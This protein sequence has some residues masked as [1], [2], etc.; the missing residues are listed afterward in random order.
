MNILVVTAHPLQD[1]L[2]STFADHTI[3]T[4]QGLNHTIVHENLYDS[5]FNPVLSA[6]EREQ[7]YHTAYDTSDLVE[8]I[9]NLKNAEVLILV[10]PTWWF[11]VPA[12]MKGWFD[13]V[14]APTVAYD[15]ASD[16]GPIRPRLVNLKK[17]LVITTLGAPWWV[18]VLVV[19]RPVQRV[20]RYALLGAC[21]KKCRYKQVS[22]YK[23]ERVNKERV[24]RFIN[25]I[26]QT[27]K[28]WI[29]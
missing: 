12:I 15:H 4:L 26:D 9:E 3:D 2:C 18:D 22:F 21:A 25:K 1:S 19:R 16:F 7:Y 11:S 24:D 29:S 6:Q 28:N 17:T 5:G 23:C 27:L 8:E 20:I 13:R 10:F 14:W